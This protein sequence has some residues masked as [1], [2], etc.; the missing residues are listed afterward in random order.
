MKNHA[1]LTISMTRAEVAWGFFFLL[2]QQF[3][4]GFL[5]QS[6]LAALGVELGTTLGLARLNG[7]YFLVNFLITVLIFRKFLAQNLLM[8]F[9]RFWNFVQAVILGYVLYYVLDWLVTAFVGL[10]PAFEN[11]NN[12]NLTDMMAVAPWLKI[13]VVFLAPVTEECLYRGLLFRLLH[14]KNRILA[15]VVTVLLFA[16]VHVLEYL[17]EITLGQAMLSLLQYLPA[18]I[19]LGWCYEKADN[20]MA[21]VLIHCLVNTLSV[22][23]LTGCA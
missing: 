13:C 15:Y 1:R 21:P 6:L 3:F 17:G 23:S 22:I 2:V 12:R 20:L 5:L 16:A 7:I 11:A 14:K 19:A 4:L 18:G 9:K 10:F 8:I